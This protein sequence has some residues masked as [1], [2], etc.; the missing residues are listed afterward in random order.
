FFGC[1]EDHFLRH[2]HDF[3]NKGDSF[4]SHVHISIQPILVNRRKVWF[5]TLLLLLLLLLRIGFLGLIIPSNSRVC[6]ISGLFLLLLLSLSLTSG[7]LTKRISWRESLLLLGLILRLLFLRLG[8]S[9]LFL[10][11]SRGLLLLILG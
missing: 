6:G 7:E 1:I 10:G 11:S 8:G 9:D 3:R 2:I 4:I 5:L